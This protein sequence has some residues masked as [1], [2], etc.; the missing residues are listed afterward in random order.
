MQGAGTV[1]LCL[2]KCKYNVKIAPICGTRTYL[3]VIL[4]SASVQETFQLDQ[5]VLS[6]MR[7]HTRLGG[8]LGVNMLY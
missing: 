8:F 1:Q 2:P 3:P 5:Q 4:H 6:V 7:D